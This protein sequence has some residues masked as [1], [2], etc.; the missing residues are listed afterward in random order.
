MQFRIREFGIKGQKGY[1]VAIVSGRGR[2]F[3]VHATFASK[4]EAAIGL[5][6]F[7]AGEG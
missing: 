7:I 4:G 6:K 2:A 5:L 3:K 1:Y